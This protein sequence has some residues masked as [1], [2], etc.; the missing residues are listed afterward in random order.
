MSGSQ[1]GAN[2]LCGLPETHVYGIHPHGETYG[3]SATQLI[4]IT[5][6]NATLLVVFSQVR[7]LMAASAYVV[8]PQQVQECRL[9]TVLK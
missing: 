9:E 6:S 4:C 3:R 2:S 8:L 1:S 5:T 7:L